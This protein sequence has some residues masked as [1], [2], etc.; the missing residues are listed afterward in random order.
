[1]LMKF[2]QIWSTFD[3][4]WSNV[5]ESWWTLVEFESKLMKLIM[6][7]AVRSQT[8]N[9]FLLNSSID[10]ESNIPSQKIR[11]LRPWGQ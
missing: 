8:A 1:M 2:D 3:E 4:N 9:S 5:D 6:E 11:N 7:F 10:S